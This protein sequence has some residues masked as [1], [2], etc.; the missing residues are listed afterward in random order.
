M[1]GRYGE[2]TYKT[3][4]DQEILLKNL[5]FSRFAKRTWKDKA[6]SQKEAGHSAKPTPAK[7]NLQ[8]MLSDSDSE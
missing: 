1:V 8:Q 2:G 7:K 4:F 6:S 3:K 5:I